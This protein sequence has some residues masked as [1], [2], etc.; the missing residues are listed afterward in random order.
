MK[1]RLTLADR[2]LIHRLSKEYNL[3][4]SEIAD[5]VGC[6]QRTVGKILKKPLQSIQEAISLADT[7]PMDDGCYRTS[8]HDSDDGLSVYQQ[9]LCQYEDP[10]FDAVAEDE[11]E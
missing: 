5:I 11:E 9:S 3:T 1:K 7:F 4:Q 6:N 2:Q 8:Y 10:T